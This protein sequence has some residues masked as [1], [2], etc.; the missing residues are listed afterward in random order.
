MLRLL[1]CWFGCSGSV[2]CVP[3]H[4]RFCANIGSV[5]LSEDE[6]RVLDEIERQLQ[7]GEPRPEGVRTRLL[8]DRQTS[9]PTP[10]LM[11]AIIG[12]FASVVVG[13]LLGGAFGVVVA[14]VGFVAIV[15]A[16]A[17]LLR[18]S[19]AAIAAQVAEIAQRY[20]VPPR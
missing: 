17:A 15:I 9:S 7:V 2:L 1:L 12:G 13:V 4:L 6:Q 18:S 11:L 10:L 20:Q 19:R 5:P 14:L 3:R 8:D 16:G